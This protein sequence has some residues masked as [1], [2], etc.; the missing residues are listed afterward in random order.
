[1]AHGRFSYIAVAKEATKGV[2][3]ATINNFLKFSGGG[4][5][6][7]AG[8]IES[9]AL[10]G[11]LLKQDTA[12]GTRSWKGKIN[13]V[14]LDSSGQGVL[15]KS[16]F[17]SE[18]VTG[19][20]VPYTHSFKFSVAD[21]Y[22]SIAVEQYKIEWLRYFL[23]TRV[24]GVS[25]KG[26]LNSFITADF[27][28]LSAKMQEGDVE[29]K[30]SVSLTG[31]SFRFYEAKVKVNDVEIP[32]KSFE[33]D[34]TE[35]AEADFNFMGGLE[36]VGIMR[37]GVEATAKFS[38]NLSETA[39]EFWNNYLGEND[40]S[41]S[42]EL[43]KDENNKLIINLPRCRVNDYKEND[44]DEILKSDITFEVLTYGTITNNIDPSIELQLVNS[45]SE[46]Y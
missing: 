20:S 26:E 37:G 30:Q 24:I 7:D 42:I 16:L 22:V 45:Q 25:I 11:R 3:P 13:G 15:F 4:F 21:D 2:K 36:A 44:G 6:L 12:I 1:M 35:K 17:G 27:D 9:K 10:T 46:V 23:N 19:S 28:L 8:K 14:E 5:E 33:V 38:L 29:N 39:L 18:T 32:V 40:V 43:V 31:S 41:V 34:I